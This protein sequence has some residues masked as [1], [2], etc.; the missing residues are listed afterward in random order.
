MTLGHILSAARAKADLSE[1]AL[2]AAVNGTSQRIAD[3]ERGAVVPPEG[4][5]SRI[6]AVLRLDAETAKAARMAVHAA[7]SNSYSK[8]DLPEHYR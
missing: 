5:L 7:V 1:A 4:E 8:T 2:A 6:I 3:I